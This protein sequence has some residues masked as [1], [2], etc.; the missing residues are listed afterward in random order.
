[1]ASYRTKIWCATCGK[2]IP[3]K[4]GGRLSKKKEL[5]CPDGHVNEVKQKKNGKFKIG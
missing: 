2:V 1:M 3:L 4:D 5:V